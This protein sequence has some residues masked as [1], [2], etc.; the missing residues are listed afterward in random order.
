MSK[1]LLLKKRIIIPKSTDNIDKNNDYNNDKISVDP[2]VN[3]NNI[4][5]FNK[6]N[7]LILTK[8]QSTC[9]LKKNLIIRPVYGLGNR[10]RALASCYSICKSL[11]LNLIINWVE[12]NHCNC[13]IHS[14]IS[15]IDDIGFIVNEEVYINNLL[16]NN[17]KIYNYIETEMNGKKDE[18]IDFD[19]YKEV[20]VKS[21]CIINSKYSYTNYNYFFKVIKFSGRVNYLINSLETTNLI[22]M[23]IRMEGGRE[24]CN[25]SYDN[26]KNWTEKETKL[27]F[28]N[29]ERSHINYFA[30]QIKIILEKDPS[31]KF[32]IATDMKSNYDKLIK[33][34]GSDKIKILER[35]VFDRSSSQIE[36]AL[37]D[38]ILLSKCNEFYGSS[39][40]SFSE[41]VIAF[42]CR[43]HSKKVCNMLSNDFQRKIN[44]VDLNMMVIGDIVFN[45]KNANNCYKN[46]VNEYESLKDKFDNYNLVL[47]VNI[48][49]LLENLNL[50]LLLEENKNLKK[51]VLNKVF[52]QDEVN[53]QLKVLINNFYNNKKFINNKYLCNIGY[54]LINKNI[55]NISINVNLFNKIKKVINEK[56]KNNSVLV[57]GNGPSAKNF[58]FNSYKTTLTM[59]NFYRYSEKINWYSNIYVSLDVVVTESNIK[60]IKEMVDNKKHELYYLD[61][62]FLKFYPGYKDNE[63]IVFSSELKDIDI[64][65]SDESLVT[66]GS[67]SVRLMLIC[68]FYNI[69]IIG[70]DCNYKRE[71]DQLINGMEVIKTTHNIIEVKENIN[72]PNYFFEGYH[73][74]G[75]R[76]N[77]PDCRLN[78]NLKKH[79]NDL[80]YLSWIQLVGAIKSFNNFN[81]KK[82]SIDSLS[83]NS[84]IKDLLNK[85]NKI[86]YKIISKNDEKIVINNEF[87]IELKSNDLLEI[88]Y[89]KYKYN[90]I[91]NQKLENRFEYLD[92]IEY[93]NNNTFELSIVIPFSIK[94]LNKE[95][96]Y[97][98][99]YTFN[100]YLKMIKKGNLKVQLCL[101][102]TEKEH[103]NFI[104]DIIVNNDVN[105]IFVKNPYNFNLGYCRNLWKYI[106]NSTKIMFNDIDIP[107]KE[108]HIIDLIKSS[109]EYDIVKPYDRNLIHTNSDER[110]EYIENNIIPNKNPKGLFSITGGITLFDKKVLLDTGGYEEFNG[111]GYEDRCLDVIVL[112]NKY[113]VKKLDNK[114]VHLYHPEIPFVGE[115]FNSINKEF[116]NCTIN[117]DSKNNIHEKCNHFKNTEGISNI[118]S[119]YNGNLNLFLDGNYQTINLKK[120]YS[121][122]KDLSTSDKRNLYNNID[123]EEYTKILVIKDT[124]KNWDINKHSMILKN[125][126]GCDIKEIDNISNYKNDLSYNIV[127]FQNTFIKITEKTDNQK[128]I[129]IVHTDSNLWNDNQICIIKENHN[130]IDTY[131]YVSNIVK[132]NFE[133]NILIPDN[134]Y[135]IENQLP[136]MK[137]DKQEIPGLFISSGSFNKMKGHF[138]LIQEFSKLDNSNTLEIYGDIHDKDYFD[139]LQKH[140]T[141]N[142]LD[143]IK[144]FDFTDKYIDRLKEAEYFCLFS[145]SEGCSYSMLE[146]ISFNKKIICSKECL[147]DNMSKYQNL[148]YEFKKF[149]KIEC[150]YDFNNFFM[151]K[152]KCIINNNYRYSIIIN[153]NFKRNKLLAFFE[154]FLL[155]GY[156]SNSNINTNE[157]FLQKILNQFNLKYDNNLYKLLNI[158]YSAV[159]IEF[160]DFIFD[161]G[162]SLESKID[163]YIK[164]LFI[165]IYEKIFYN[166]NKNY[167]N[168]D[169]VILIDRLY[170]ALDFNVNALINLYKDL[171]I[172]CVVHWMYE[173]Y[174]YKNNN[175]NVLSY[176]YWS[177]EWFKTLLYKN[178]NY[179]ICDYMW[180]ST[181][182]SEDK[183]VESHIK[184]LKLIENKI[185]CGNEKQKLNLKNITNKDDIYLLTEISLFNREHVISKRDINKNNW[186]L[187]GGTK[188]NVLIIGN[189]DTKYSHSI[190]KNYEF[191]DVLIKKFSYKCN[192]IILD[193]SKKMYSQEEIYDY[194]CK[195]D[196][197]LTCSKCE[198]APR[199]IIDGVACGIPFM[200]SIYTT[201]NTYIDLAKTYNLDIGYLCKCDDDFINYFQN[202]T[203]EDI[204]TKKK[205]ATIFT[206]ILKALN[207]YNLYKILNIYHN[208]LVSILIPCYNTNK[209]FFRKTLDSIYEQTYKNIEVV[210]IED[211]NK[212]DNLELIEEFKKKMNIKYYNLNKNYGVSTALAVGLNLCNGKYIARMDSD[213][214]MIKY[215][216]S[217]QINYYKKHEKTNL[218]LLGGDII[219]IDNDDNY[220]RYNYEERP[221]FIKGKQKEINW[222]LNHPTVFFNKEKFLEYGNYPLN[223]KNIAE[224][225]ILWK[226]ILN[227]GGTIINMDEPVILYRVHDDQV[228]CDKSFRHNTKNETFDGIVCTN[229]FDI[230]SYLL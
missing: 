1:K 167:D 66:T 36:Y 48:Y 30:N 144:L 27:M 129:Y 230:T 10:L 87:K 57:I 47:K 69:N 220:K 214:I 118:N 23:H 74:K 204:L 224:D 211:G 150:Y 172:E 67:D 212:N 154:M 60:K 126:L 94:N 11:G 25:S 209:N 4:L 229:N 86:I 200:S 2:T 29:R 116:Y 184:S 81:H 198:G 152:Y 206:Y 19:K 187:Y 72:N 162:L 38:I 16:D 117:L 215:R 134:S 185:Y 77:F 135:V 92:N 219:L 175:L 173:D 139:M 113:T 158:S 54:Y 31:K 9:I 223:C 122:N 163:I 183:T 161:K 121:K 50:N 194:L 130:I 115:T 228:T 78:D 180:D 221:S 201:G 170:W 46:L 157:E 191:Y 43:Y 58:R 182:Y 24:Y 45:N 213:D 61:D 216:I 93:L 99:K 147:T 5:I 196:L 218:L 20:F 148:S 171:N 59:N 189:F 145:K 109:K 3:N 153:N 226:D 79:G 133:K 159:V 140:I 32:F 95:S 146:A 197:V 21:N 26:Y 205:Q 52:T 41:I 35:N 125:K 202:F 190:V 96:E 55:N 71:N 208:D 63:L 178:V 88:H 151:L 138:E 18:F 80:H 136:E 137:N 100:E 203:E 97:N 193:A 8:N 156:S 225:A 70:I 210:I 82:V 98:F 91:I 169:I 33:F 174:K 89:Y 179:H 102:H 132:D 188:I 104:D 34:Y 111:H 128:F 123:M 176:Q 64:T 149:E 17:Y 42:Q 49:C 105:Y 56:T 110:T 108:N 76:L 142:K 103:D 160:K 192:F 83:K 120:I 68:N 114:I 155:I 164:Y 186:F 39:W 14:L 101:V 181:F 165:D 227:K 40:S 166:N 37:A 177:L 168:I 119:K 195:T 90:L 107:L 7:R 131:I 28:E 124:N 44:G 73:V 62:I 22:G 199:T 15:N 75:D 84:R 143:N 207:R 222:L 51:L 65:F 53:K 85:D 127:L 6:P 141:D 112:N 13:S 12:D 217:C 106:C